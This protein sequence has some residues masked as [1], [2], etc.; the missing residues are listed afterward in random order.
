MPSVVQ[1]AD[2]KYK[3]G[4]TDKVHP[5]RRDMVHEFAALLREDVQGLFDAGTSYVQ[6][7]GPS[8]LTHLMDEGRR[9]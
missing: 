7:D 1:F 8:Y 5:T 6:L 3:A 2:S 4:V 9:Q